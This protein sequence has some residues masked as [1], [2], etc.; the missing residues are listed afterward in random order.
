[1]AQSALR[2]RSTPADRA[3]AATLAAAI[4]AVLT[5]G[6]SLTPSPTGMGTHKQ[7]GLPSCGWI[8]SADTPCPTCGMTTAFA[9]VAHGDLSA[10]F[11]AQPMGAIGAI[12]AAAVFWACL[13]IALTGSR[14][15]SVAFRLLTP[16]LLWIVGA[17]WAA[18][19]VYKVIASR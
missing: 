12:V 6:A 7:L 9:A 1:M 17:V 18:S 14:L 2:A 8:I 11:A 13:H 10:A 3:I 15:G 4:L 5:I 19:W 16:R